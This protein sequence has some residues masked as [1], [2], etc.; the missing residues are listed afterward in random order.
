MKH[1][2]RP[3]RAPILAVALA[4]AFSLSA[5]A[6]ATATADLQAGTDI[7]ARLVGG[8]IAVNV[9]GGLMTGSAAL[10]ALHGWHI[11]KSAATLNFTTDFFT[12]FPAFGVHSAIVGAGAP[13]A[14]GFTE[15]FTDPT[16]INHNVTVA[17]KGQVLSMLVKTFSGE[18][19]C[20]SRTLHQP[21]EDVFD[22]NFRGSAFDT[23]QSSFTITGT[24][25]VSGQTVPVV[26]G[27]RPLVSGIGGTAQTDFVK[28]IAFGAAAITAGSTHTTGVVTLESAPSDGAE[29]VSMTTSGPITVGSPSVVVPQFHATAT[30]SFTAGD[31]PGPRLGSV[32]ATANGFSLTSSIQV[33]PILASITSIDATLVAGAKEAFVINLSELAPAGGV[34]VNL[35]IKTSDSVLQSATLLIPAGH[36]YG[37]VY[38]QT[39]VGDANVTIGASLGT[40]SIWRTFPLT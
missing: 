14:N 31:V 10:P 37:T 25:M 2:F 13:T 20:E 18:I 35:S 5:A 28:L 19:T 34:T 4:A 6:S 7:Q 23:L 24:T 17:V 39:T 26:V 15:T 3:K 22:H 32:T 38:V 12:L 9:G 30:F 36:S 40:A 21:L 16:L 27:I 8:V 29:T 33:V 1:L 11:A